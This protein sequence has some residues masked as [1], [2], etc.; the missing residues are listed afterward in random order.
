[1]SSGKDRNTFYRN[2]IKRRENI[3]LEG[4]AQNK[5]WYNLEQIKIAAPAPSGFAEERARG[6]QSGL[7]NGPW[8]LRV[9]TYDAIF[10]WTDP[11]P[12]PHLTRSS[13]AGRVGKRLDRS[14][15]GTYAQVRGVQLAAGLGKSPGRVSVEGTCS[16]FR[17]HVRGGGGV[18]RPRDRQVTRVP[19]APRVRWGL[20]SRGNLKLNSWKNGQTSN[21]HFPY[22]LWTKIEFTV[23]QALFDSHFRYALGINTNVGVILFVCFVIIC[24]QDIQ[25]LCN[26]VNCSCASTV[27]KARVYA[28]LKGKEWERKRL[29]G[30]VSR[31]NL[32]LYFREVCPETSMRS[33][34][35]APSMHT[36]YRLHDSWALSSATF[37]V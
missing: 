15:R 24:G 18:V 3:F 2:L 25:A 28:M 13:G 1:M 17:F 10:R 16:R 11:P 4:W 23:N 37:N 12:W 30:L 31:D 22:S 7:I 19:H 8:F 29:C 27:I 9:V 6:P 20:C 33:H 32:H 21:I 26:V 36:V 34:W 35:P 5:F 14:P